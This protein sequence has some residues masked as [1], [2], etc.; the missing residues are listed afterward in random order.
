MPSLAAGARF[1]FEPI[2]EIDGGEEAAARAGA[3]AASRDG[4]GEMG[5][6]GSGA[7]DQDDVAL[8]GDEAAAGEIA[9]QA[10]VDRRVLEGEVV[11]VL[12][13]RQ[14]GDRHLVFDRAR[15]LFRDLGLQKVADEALAAR[16]CA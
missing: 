14:L 8:L 2:D 16:A 1:G 7:A 13:E 10:L 6:A 4:D 9:H 3:D 11:D 5:L 15:L 12:G